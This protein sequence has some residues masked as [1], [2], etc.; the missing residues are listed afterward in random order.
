MFSSAPSLSY[1]PST[2]RPVFIVG[3][4]RSGTTLVEQIIASHH[5]VYGAGELTTLPTLIAPIARDHLAK[6]KYKLPEKAFL[7]IRQQYLDAL[8]GFNISISPMP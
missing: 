3:M 2:I 7:S 5:A 4:P 6:D 1:E 8:S